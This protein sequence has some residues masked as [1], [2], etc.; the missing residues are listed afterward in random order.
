MGAGGLEECDCV[1]EIVLKEYTK[2]VLLVLVKIKFKENFKKRSIPATKW[3]DGRIMSPFH[4]CLR[5]NDRSCSLILVGTND[6]AM[7]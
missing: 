6:P 5:I 7:A 1:S 2:F 4:K 3:S